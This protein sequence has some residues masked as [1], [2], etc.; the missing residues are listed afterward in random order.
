MTQSRSPYVT[1]VPVSRKFNGEPNLVVNEVSK[2]GGTSL[3]KTLAK[4]SDRPTK[5][6][7][8]SVF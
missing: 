5:M 3:S 4:Q 2:G 6:K 8:V 7:A 1:Y